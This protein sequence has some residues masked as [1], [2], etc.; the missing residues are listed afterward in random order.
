[1]ERILHVPHA[2]GVKP[3]FPWFKFAPN[4]TG[5]PTI[6]MNRGKMVSTVARSAAGVFLVTMSDNVA[7]SPAILV[8][9]QVPGDATDIYAQ[10]GDITSLTPLTFQ[11]RLMTAGTPTDVAADTNASVSVLVI[12]DDSGA[13]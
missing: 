5:A 7:Q 4:G 3:R 12:T 1:M 6:S 11:V 13:A 10:L 2:N 8:T 9:A